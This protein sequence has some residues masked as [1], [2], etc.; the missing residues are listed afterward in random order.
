MRNS[1]RSGMPIRPDRRQVVLGARCRPLRRRP[2]GWRGQFKARI[3]VTVSVNF[4]NSVLRWD[5]TRRRT[6]PIRR[7]GQVTR[8]RRWRLTGWLP[9][10]G[11]PRPMTHFSNF[12]LI[13][14]KRLDV[15]TC[16]ENYFNY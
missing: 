8:R 7:R 15:F 11:W 9:T 2:G 4:G 1:V 14:P 10:A 6:F 3:V 13:V 5:S 12:M 16:E